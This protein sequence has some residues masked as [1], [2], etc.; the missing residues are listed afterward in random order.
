VFVLGL[1]VGSFLNVVIARVPHGQSIVRP[2]SRC[3]SCGHVLPW[4][5]NLPLVSWLALRGR[6]RGCRA[7][8]SLRYPL[9]ELLTALLFLA[10]W[11]RFGIGWHLGRAMLLVGFLV[12]LAF[13]DL[14]HWI[15]P[16]SLTVP[17]AALGLVSAVPLGLPALR[18]AALG[19]AVG[20]LFFW[21]LE[22]VLLPGVLRV[23]HRIRR[24]L[25]KAS[26]DESPDDGFVEALGAGDKWLML[27]VGSY[28]GYRPLFG[29]LLLSNVQG[30]LVGIV[31]VLLFGRAAPVAP[32]PAGP[33]ADDDWTPGPTH[34]P[35]GPWIALAALELLLLGPILHALFPGPIVGLLTG[36]PWDVP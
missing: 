6:C 2:G 17:G 12:P 25:R 14:K 10:C 11:Q 26:P 9:I 33:A 36:E 7:A 19:A 4:Y 16:F 30:A 23:L 3:P 34:L 31:L 22:R 15:L 35:F 28:L 1:V 29:V 8:I 13:I 32:D 20:F 18:D 27:L 21:F 24:A 5:E